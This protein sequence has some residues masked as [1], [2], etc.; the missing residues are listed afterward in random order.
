MI[1]FFPLSTLGVKTPTSRTKILVNRDKDVLI[2]PTQTT[3][4]PQ[5][6]II[7][8]ICCVQYSL[9]TYPS[10]PIF[11]DVSLQGRRAAL[12]D[13]MFSPRLLFT[14]EEYSCFARV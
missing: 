1:F 7:H 5:H 2:S 14:T 3:A 4:P 13:V 11:G 8:G 10:V 9:F 6:T 12:I